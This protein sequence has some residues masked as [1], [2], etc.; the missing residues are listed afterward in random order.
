MR[1][2]FIFLLI[3]TSLFG[4]DY[5]LSKQVANG[6]TALLR[7]EKEKG[8]TF[9]YVE[10]DKKNFPFLNTQDNTQ[11][12]ALIPVSYYAKAGEKTLRVVYTKD[13]VTHKK[14]F[15]FDV[16]YGEYKKERI[17]VSSKKVNPQ[18]PKV[19]K[20]I[21]KEY[22]EAMRIYN[23]V[24][25]TWY[26]NKPFVMPLDSVI[27]SDFGK[28]RVYNGSLKGYHSGT[29]FRAPVGT[30][31]KASNDGKV[32]LVANRFYSGGTIIINHGKGLY[33]CYFHLSKFLV[34]EGDE[35]TENQV[36]AL[37]GKSGRV[38]GPHLHFAARIN[39]VQVDPL[40]LITLINN[41]LT[42]VQ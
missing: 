19:K 5:T 26:I 38:T 12:F 13:G 9:E 33:T 4:F 40:Q 15:T 21:A 28:A 8:V 39:G 31:I 14:N 36:I 37:S 29:D 34:D 2:F 7:V 11:R 16:V 18:A 25:D 30:P 1:L 42:K 41:T 20:R 17:Q 22:A 6:K 27:T 10:F 3:Y 24:D 32:V 23:T 35:V